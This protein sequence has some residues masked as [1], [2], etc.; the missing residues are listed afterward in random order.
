VPRATSNNVVAKLVLGVGHVEMVNQQS[1]PPPPL[2]LKKALVFNGASSRQGG[3]RG[4]ANEHGIV[5]ENGEGESLGCRAS[6]TAAR[7]QQ[8]GNLRA[9]L[10]RAQ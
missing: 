3:A 7:P 9:A 10:I 5:R 1:L 4:L 2:L 8:T 6:E